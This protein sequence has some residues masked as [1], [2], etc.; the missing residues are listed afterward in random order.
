MAAYIQREN[1]RPYTVSTMTKDSTVMSKLPM[2]VTAHSGMLS[3]KPQ[4]VDGIDELLRQ[5]GGA[6]AACPAVPMTCE[7]MPCTM[8]NTASIRSMLKSTA[9]F[10]SANR[11][12]NLSACSGRRTSAKLP[13]VLTTPAAK[14][15]TS[16]PY[17]MACS[18]AV[19]AGHDAP[20]RAAVV[21]DRAGGQQLPDLGQLVVPGV[22]GVGQVIHDPV[23][24]RIASPPPGSRSPRPSRACPDDQIENFTGKRDDNAARQRQKALA[25]LAGV[26]ALQR[27]PHLHD[28]PSKQ[29]QTDGPDDAENEGVQVVD[30]GQWVA[31][32]QGGRCQAA[33][34]SGN[35]VQR[36]AT[37][38]AV[39]GGPLFSRFL[40]FDTWDS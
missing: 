16:S 10:A 22:E 12:N 33:G 4:A 2:S 37:A 26:V 31:S 30:D 32:R 13:Q 6:D 9:A 25:A 14:N 34:Q 29:D 28:A 7:I 23:I 21:A 1:I 27:Q 3:Q 38:Q 15:S 11:T 20:H 19:D 17:P 18:G 24:V 40:F 35:G 8:S 36:K 39:G 5:R